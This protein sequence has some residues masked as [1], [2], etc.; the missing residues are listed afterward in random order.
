VACDAGLTRAAVTFAESP[1]GACPWEEPD[2]QPARRHLGG[3]PRG[4]PIDI[5][6]A[7]ADMVVYNGGAPLTCLA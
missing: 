4:A 2:E 1:A 6:A 5:A 7:L 3:T